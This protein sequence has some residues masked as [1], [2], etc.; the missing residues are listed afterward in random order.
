[1]MV[2]REIQD[3]Y[4][5]V[6][7]ELGDVVLKV[8]HLSSD[9]FH[10][11]SFEVRKGEIFGFGGLVGSKRTEVL[12]TIFGVRPM[13]GGKI[14]LN[15]EEYIPKNPEHAIENGFAFV[16][17]DRK[18]TG[19]VSC[20]SIF[21]NLNMLNAKHAVKHGLLDFKRMKEIAQ[22]QKASLNIRISNMG[23]PVQTLSGGNMQKVALGKWLDIKP[24]I[25]LFDEP[26]RGIDTVSYTHL[27][28]P[29]I[30]SV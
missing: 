29:T 28:L 20:L 9:V 30:C 16:T 2:G 10:D 6:D 1:M 27:T 18:K 11:I 14:W 7:V 5:K 15:G 4:A 22:E 17:E 8:E 26:T 23:L 13:K 3:V 25:I 12:E 21:E 19:L 24:K